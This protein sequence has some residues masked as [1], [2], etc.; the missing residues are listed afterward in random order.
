MSLK[1]NTVLVLHAISL[2]VVIEYAT[3][4]SNVK[5]VKTEMC[6]NL[7]KTVRGILLFTSLCTKYV[8]LL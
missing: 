1:E 2:L 4:K 7:D 6:L 3:S 5:T 8:F